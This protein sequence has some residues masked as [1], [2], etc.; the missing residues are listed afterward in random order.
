MGLT[1]SGILILPKP[2]SCVGKRLRLLV[3]T[4]LLLLLPGANQKSESEDE[5]ED[6]EEE[7]EEEEE[8]DEDDEEEENNRTALNPRRPRVSPCSPVRRWR[9]RR[10]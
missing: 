3:F 8:E 10:G 5:D 4:A 7:E 2:L 1:T 9:R 6:E